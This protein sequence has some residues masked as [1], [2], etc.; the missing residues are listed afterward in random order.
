[1]SNNTKK[2][3]EPQIQVRTLNLP[4]FL[5][6][7]TTLAPKMASWADDDSST[8]GSEPDLDIVVPPITT[9]IAATPTAKSD[10]N[11]STD[12][13][14]FKVWYKKHSTT[15]ARVLYD[16]TGRALVDEDGNTVNIFT[17][18][19]KDM[20]EKKAIVCHHRPGRPGY[21]YFCTHP[22]QADLFKRARRRG[23]TSFV[24]PFHVY[25]DEPGCVLPF[26]EG[27]PTA[28]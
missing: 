8:S 11:E 4:F 1:M 23:M 14:R 2:S 13:S 24:G 21:R 28:L 16:V 17:A 6:R 20:L 3:V 26:E 15:Y 22:S 5:N 9:T 19:M 12:G 18:K 7:M 25:P 10:D 27:T